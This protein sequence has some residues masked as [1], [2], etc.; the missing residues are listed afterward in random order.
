M[1]KLCGVLVLMV[2]CGFVLADVKPLPPDPVPLPVFDVLIGNIPTN[3]TVLQDAQGKIEI[4]GFYEPDPMP[5]GYGVVVTVYDSKGGVVTQ[6]PGTMDGKGVWVL[7]A[8]VPVGNGYKIT[9]WINDT[10]AYDTVS[11]ITVVAP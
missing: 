4:A 11:N 7:T 8:T 2:A 6:R 10:A 9:A 5:F 1:R 3:G